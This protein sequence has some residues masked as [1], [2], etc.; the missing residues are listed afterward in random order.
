MPK[1]S[2]IPRDP[3]TAMGL[4]VFGIAVLY[5]GST[6]PTPLYPEYRRAFNLTELDITRI[7]AAYV[8]GNLLVLFIFGRLSD[9]IGRRFTAMIAFV[10]AL[11]SAVIF[12]C[13]YNG[14]WLYAARIGNGVSAGLGA[15]ALTAWIAELEPRRDQARASVL[16]SAGNLAGLAAGALIAGCLARFARWPLHLSYGV[17]L[18]L[19][20]V[21]M[22]CLVPARETVEHPKSRWRDLSL[23]PRLGVP[24]GIRMAFVTPAALAFTAFAL[25]GFYAALTPGMLAQRLHVDN[26]AVFGAVVGLFFIAAAAVAF[27]A[28]RIRIRAAVVSAIIL[29]VVGIGLL[30]LAEAEASM[31]LLLGAT[32]LTGASMA[33]GYRGSLQIVNRIAPPAQR[34]EVISSYLM[35]CYLANSLPV[36]GV[37][38]L[39]QSLGANAAHR[40]FAAALCA[41]ALGAA[42]IGWRYL[43]EP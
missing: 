20:A 37:G 12:L 42:A 22:L 36:I 14:A 3:A 10:V 38:L 23:R 6:L 11:V 4:A 9:Q 26:A 2:R 34:S 40:I 19:I 25:A 16:A 15:G 31:P 39:S 43:P 28:A 5:V 27:L 30:M 13:A 24:R 33:I 41:L 7:Y 21:A 8:I 18:G 29:L 1:N 17:Y 35:V 32:L